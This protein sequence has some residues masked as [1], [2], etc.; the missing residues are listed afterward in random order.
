MM[1]VCR[2]WR[3]AGWRNRMREGEAAAEVTDAALMIMSIANRFHG[4][5]RIM[6]TTGL[7]SLRNRT[8][9]LAAALVLTG[10]A[11]AAANTIPAE[12]RLVAA[13]VDLILRQTVA[14]A[15]ARARPATIVVTD[16]VGNV[17]AVYAMPGAPATARVDPGRQVVSP[18][19]VAGDPAGLANLVHGYV[20][21]EGKRVDAY[22]WYSHFGVADGGMQASMPDLVRFV[23]IV[24]T[25]DLILD[26]A[27]REVF[28]TPSGL[29][30]PASD[31]A[32]GIQTIEGEAPG[33]YIYGHSGKDPGY[34][35]DFLHVQTP[36][37]SLTLALA[38][39]GS[40]EPYDTTYQW[41]LQ[42]VLEI[43]ADLKG[44]D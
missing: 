32:L 17:L 37:G 14:E 28:T 1:I 38:A 27:M 30:Q 25:T 15:T 2:L 5:N 12:T 29:G 23:R 20:D 44:G 16:R 13:D 7:A 4:G 41:L 19:G 35:A 11:S 22:P 31:Y 10:A 33:E 9:R 18:G 21:D 42:T 39:G 40:F 8:I 36:S 43:L 24:L 6:G 34:Q 3:E 26:E